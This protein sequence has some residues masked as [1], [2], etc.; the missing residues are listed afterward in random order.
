MPRSS[1][2]PTLIC[3]K[4]S[5]LVMPTP[6]PEAMIT[7]GAAAAT[8]APAT[9]TASQ[10]GGRRRARSF[11]KDPR[12]G[13]FQRVAAGLRQHCP[14]AYPVAIRTVWLPDHIEGTCSRRR[15]QFSIRIADRLDERSAVE[16]LLHEWAH[17]RSWNHR[18]DACPLAFP[19]DPDLDLEFDQLAHGPEWGIAYSLVWRVFTGWILPAAE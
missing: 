15:S 13:F 18:L 5:S 7:P 2:S 19:T 14:A 8:T 11:M 3:C 17:A 6:Q 4:A 1:P 16:V 9:W 12:C 10:F